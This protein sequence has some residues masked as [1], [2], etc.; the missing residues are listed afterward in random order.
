[1]LPRCASAYV[2]LQCLWSVVVD[3]INNNNLEIGNVIELIYLEFKSEDEV[4]TC[5]ATLLSL[6]TPGMDQS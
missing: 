2:I 1:M 4:K 5:V 3:K 6:S